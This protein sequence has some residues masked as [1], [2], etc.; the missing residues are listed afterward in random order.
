VA[1]SPCAAF[2]APPRL[3]VIVPVLDDAQEIERNLP[4]L[5][6]LRGAGHEVLVVDGGSRDASRRAASPH[7]SRVLRAARGRA[8]QMNAGAAAAAGDILLFLHADTQ[9]PPDADRLVAEAMAARRRHWGR[10]DVRIAEDGWPYRVIESAMNFRS[11]L[12]GMATGDQ[13]IFVERAA[14]DAV[15]GFPDIPLME[16]IAISRRLKALSRPACLR[17]RVVTS[18]RRWQKDGLLRTVLLMWR[19]R[20]AY[21]LGADP[22]RLA[23]LYER[24]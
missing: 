16:D 8:R 5:D 11:R 4:A 21:V 14:F 6:A 20:L 19:L 18:A 23:R 7:A 9:L 12:T 22:G 2:V 3:S 15:G 13:V 1:V 24:G 17:A 10:F